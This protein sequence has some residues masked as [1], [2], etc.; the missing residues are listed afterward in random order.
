M[1]D[2][3]VYTSIKNNI[4]RARALAVTLGEIVGKVVRGLPSKVTAE[5]LTVNVLIPPDVYYKHRNLGRIGTLLGVVDIK[6]LYFVLLRTVG[7]ERVD[8]ASVVYSDTSLINTTETSEEEPGSLITNVLAKC[9]MLTKYD[10]LNGGPVES[11]DLVIEP[12][13]P[14]IIP[15]PDIVEKALDLNRGLL[16][17]GFLE[18]ANNVRVSASFDDLNYHMLVVGT[19]G[20]GKTSFIKNMIA[21]TYLME[22]KT[23]VF[24]LDTTGDYYHIFLP[25][26]FTSPIVKE[27]LKSFSDLVGNVRGIDVDIVYPVTKEWIRKYTRGLGDKQSI[28]T[29]YYNNY[30]KPVVDFL[31]RKGVKLYVSVDREGIHISSSEWTAHARIHPFYFTFKGAKRILPKLNPYFS[32]QASHF[33]RIILEKHGDEIRGFKSLLDVM[34]SDIGEQMKIHKSTKENIVR[35]IYLLTS[36]GLFNVKAERDSLKEVLSS[37]Y[38]VVVFDL[39]NSE[40]NDFAQKVL[41]YYVLDRI[42]SYRE[43]QMR[44]GKLEDRAIIII[45]EAHKFFPSSKGSEE[46][47]NYV[48]RV[49]GKIALMMRL[50]RRRK[51]G[52]VFATHNPN[53]LSEIIVQLSNNKVVFRTKPEVAE[54]FGL[55]RTEALV[56]SRERNGVAYYISPWLRESKIKIRVPIPPPLGHYDLSRS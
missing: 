47:T 41:I 10:V 38:R 24:V 37:G 2:E 20:T 35:G 13:S 18:N 25:P 52:F 30:V 12:Q 51:I 42:F 28:I 23:K 53:D 44:A 56:L 3:D 27:S 50:G 1:S 34:E 5:E 32:E 4:E 15:R 49:A 14:V 11:A 29:A 46:D 26:D 8:A 54:S 16:R 36:T 17:L 45:D 40:M 22:D 21:T 43:A 7:Y 9:E 31:A 33:L 6:S 39:Y 19:T 55:S 48:R